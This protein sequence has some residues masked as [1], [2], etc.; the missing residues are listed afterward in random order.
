MNQKSSDNQKMHTDQALPNLTRRRLARGGLAA[1]V[2]L[3]SV[4]SRNAFAAT[5]YSCTVSGKLS[6]NVSPFGP[7]TDPNA[8]CSLRDGQSVLRDRLKNDQT[9]FA[10]AGFSTSY[11]ANGSNDKGSKLGSQPFQKPQ[12]SQNA[13]LYQVLSISDYASA[14][15][16]PKDPEFAK[17][18]VVLYQN[19]TPGPSDQYPLTR[20]QVAAMFNAAIS[21]QD[22]NGST[23]MGAFTWTPTDVRKYFQQLYH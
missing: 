9:T 3:A 10:D 1:P 7:N 18:A 4:V 23:S 2:V 8:S 5:P 22:Y 6:G 17:M 11:F 21:N 13:T 12:E 14:G 20:T 19:A 15:A 16:A